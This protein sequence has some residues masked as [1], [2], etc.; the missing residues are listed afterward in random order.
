MATASRWRAQRSAI[1]AA[2]TPALSS[3]VWFRSSVAPACP[4]SSWRSVRVPR[5]HR[6]LPRRHISFVVL[7]D[8][9]RSLGVGPPSRE[10]WLGQRRAVLSVRARLPVVVG[11]AVGLEGGSAVASGRRAVGLR[12]HGSA[13]GSGWGPWIGGLVF[14]VPGGG[15]SA[16]SA[17]AGTVRLEERRWAVSP[18]D[19]V[20]VQ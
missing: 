14:P 16:R 20:T 2:L 15:L 7:P 8:S 13:A 1:A 17:G 11:C 6:G 4:G 18:E 5:A 10:P 9:F 3:S 19:S 12:W